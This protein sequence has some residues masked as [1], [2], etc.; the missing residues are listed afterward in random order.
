MF[1]HCLLLHLSS[2]YCFLLFQQQL[3]TVNVCFEPKFS[4]ALAF[5]NMYFPTGQ[6]YQQRYILKDLHL[7]LPI[8]L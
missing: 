5:P 4:F 3:E 6:K 8:R 7:T 1:L 2:D